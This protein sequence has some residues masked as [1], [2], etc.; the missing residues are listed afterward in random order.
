MPVGDVERAVA[1]QLVDGAVVG[2]PV[3]EVAD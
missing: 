1:Q 3:A 2:R